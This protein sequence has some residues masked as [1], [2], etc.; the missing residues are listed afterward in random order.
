MPN[1]A[2][3]HDRKFVG[4]KLMDSAQHCRDQAA[5]CVRLMDSA[6][7]KDQARLLGNISVSWSRL[8]GQIDRYNALVRDQLCQRN[9]EL[10]MNT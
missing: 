5:E 7:T 9:G 4:G 3:R 10:S 8:A 6:P 2:F 1:S